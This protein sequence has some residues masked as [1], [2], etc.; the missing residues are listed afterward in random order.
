LRGIIQ[1]RLAD[2]VSR[3]FPKLTERECR[4][5]LDA[6]SVAPDAELILVNLGEEATLELDGVPIQLVSTRKWLLDKP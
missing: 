3:E 5:L 4:V 6:H 2:D 1:Q